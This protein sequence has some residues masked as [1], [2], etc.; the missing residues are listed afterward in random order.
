MKFTKIRSKTEYSR[1]IIFFRD[2]FDIFSFLNGRTKFCTF[3]LNVFRVN[4][5]IQSEHKLSHMDVFVYHLEKSLS[6]RVDLLSKINANTSIVE[7]TK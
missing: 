3:S 4:F 2:Y 5:V 7:N 1:Q 6:R